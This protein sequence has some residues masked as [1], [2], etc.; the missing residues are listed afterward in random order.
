M[1]GSGF[2]RKNARS[3]VPV[4]DAAN[5][6][7]CRVREKNVTKFFREPLERPVEAH[8]ID[9]LAVLVVA[10]DTAPIHAKHTPGRVV[11]KIA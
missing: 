11:R 10:V 4:P 5:R 7:I 8:E 1:I 9:E 6:F 2:V 3:T